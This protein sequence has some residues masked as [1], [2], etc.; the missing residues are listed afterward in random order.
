MSNF[1]SPITLSIVGPFFRKFT[2]L[3]VALPYNAR[4][5]SRSD[6]ELV[7]VLDEP[8]QEAEVLALL[9][10]FPLLRVRV[11]VN[12]RSHDWRPPCVAINVGIQNALGEYVLVVS[13]ESVLVGDVPSRV[14]GVLRDHPSDVLLGR[15][16]FATYSEAHGRTSEALFPAVMA[17]RG[18]HAFAM[19]YYGTVAASRATFNAVRGYDESL[20]DWGGDDDN[21]RARLSMQ[22]ALLVLDRAL[23]VIHLS[24]EPRESKFC[25]ERIEAL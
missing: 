6:V 22:G 24:E 12:D 4:Y 21:L 14:I 19:D 15:V 13:P 10:S 3:G 2:E 8:S 25:F 1:L 7:L 18:G 23:G 17:V 11:V 5:L 20:S 9:D 16:A